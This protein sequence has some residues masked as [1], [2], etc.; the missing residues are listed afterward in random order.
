AL[1]GLVVFA[2]SSRLYGTAGGLLSLTLWTFCPNILAHGRLITTDIGATALGVGATYL[3]WRYLKS[4]SWGRAT[5]AGLALGAA[6]LSKF[7]MLL[8]Y[9]I[10]PLLWLL[11]KLARRDSQRPAQAVAHGAWI[12]VLSFVLIDVG[13]AF[14]G[15][16]VPLGSFEF[17]CRALT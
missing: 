8:L 16:G 11:H 13:Y 6:E 10:W 9:A 14:E 7:S 5:A 3:F 1:G 17:A 4:P 2:W 12:V 15:V